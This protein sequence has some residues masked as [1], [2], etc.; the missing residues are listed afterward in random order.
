MPS[1]PVRV[2]RRRFHLPLLGT[3]TGVLVVLLA[4]VLAPLGGTPTA[5]TTDAPVDL[6]AKST[7]PVTPGNFIGLGFDQCET[8]SQKNMDT[9]LEHSPFRAVGVYISGAS[10]FCK[11]QKNLTPEWVATQLA[12][13]WRILPIT[14]GPQSSC[15]GRFPRYGAAIDP[16][17]VNDTANAYAAARAQGSAEADSAVAAATAL[18]IVPGSTLWYDLEGW[19]LSKGNQHCTEPALAFMSAWTARVRQLGYVSGV[20]SS[21]GS[22]IKILDDARLQGR[23]DVT[24]PDRIW[25]ARWDNVANTST[26]YIAEDGWRPGHRVKQYQGGHNE[27][28]GGVTINID[29]NWLE[30]GDVAGYGCGGVKVSLKTYKKI[31]PRKAKPRQVRALKCLLQGKGLYP[32][33][34]SK[35]YNKKLRAGIH[36]WQAQ[37]G[38]KVKDSWTKK[39]WASLLG[40]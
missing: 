10:R 31:T 23:A 4:L 8:Q 27:T 6:A 24:L 40:G 32:G 36:A 1:R 26:S 9:W 15:V 14:L 21:A 38:Q 35:K 16:T 34:M 30:L 25:I 11:T 28:W 7:N 12:K 17:I 5:T 2:P 20:Y 18:G 19:G 39:N 29:R 3:G 22:G 37:A 13:G 33:K